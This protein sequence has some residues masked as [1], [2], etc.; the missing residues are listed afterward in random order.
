M[1]NE[2]IA[3]NMVW[4]SLSLEA[5]RLLLAYYAGVPFIDGAAQLELFERGLFDG[6]SITTNGRVVVRDRS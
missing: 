3:A 6:Q 4:T 2:T 1:T 5:Q